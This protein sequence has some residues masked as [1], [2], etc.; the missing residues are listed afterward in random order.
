MVPMSSRTNAN[1][2]IEWETE[3][4]RAREWTLDDVEAAFAMYGDMDVQRGLSGEVVPHLEAQREWLSAAIERSRSRPYGSGYWALERKTDRAVVGA[5]LVKPI[6]E[7]E[8]KIE[9]GWHLAKR[10]WGQGYAIEAAHGAA[11]VAF[12]H[13]P[14]DRLY[15]VVYPW[16][17]RSINVARKLGFVQ[18]PG[19]HVIYD[20]EVFLF[21]LPRSAEYTRPS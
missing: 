8:E 19:I 13:L 3:R 2:L 16:N 4:L 11:K 18:I 7:D 5:S 20:R 1:G 15:C 10:H 14:I 21:E 17:E 9:I 6:P 12:Q